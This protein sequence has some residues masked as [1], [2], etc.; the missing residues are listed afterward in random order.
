MSSGDRVHVL[1]YIY[2]VY[3]INIRRVTTSFHR[4][5][6]GFPPGLSSAME[7]FTAGKRFNGHSKMAV[8]S[9]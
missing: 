7:F 3:H 4:V 6:D 1:L 2:I 8:F 9:G 5:N